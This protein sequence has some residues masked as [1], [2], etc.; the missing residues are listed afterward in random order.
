MGKYAQLVIGPAGC[1]KVRVGR[2]QA[3]GRRQADRGCR[4]PGAERTIHHHSHS[5]VLPRV[6]PKQSTYCNHLLEHCQA[7]KRSVHIVNLGGWCGEGGGPR[8]GGGRGMRGCAGR[9]RRACTGGACTLLSCPP[10]RRP[11]SPPGPFPHPPTRPRLASACMPWR[12]AA[13]CA[14]VTCGCRPR[15]RAVQLPGVPGHPGPHHAGGCNGGAGAGAKRVRPVVLVGRCWRTGLC[16]CG[17]GGLTRTWGRQR[18]RAVNGLGHEA[19]G[20]PSAG[21][22]RGAP[23]P[24]SRT[25]AGAFCGKVQASS[26]VS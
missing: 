16:V 4:H 25:S 13:A 8:A 1:G 24:E 5:S 9:G 2:M 19:A 20:G 10:P 26:H 21:E 6:A 15:S 22:R 14:P 3:G 18:T 7:I 23:G 12:G 17:G 11:P